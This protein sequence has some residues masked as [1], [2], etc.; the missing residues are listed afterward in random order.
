MTCRLLGPVGGC[1]SSL[2]AEGLPADL[3]VQLRQVGAGSRVLP[4]S[5]GPR[6]WAVQLGVRG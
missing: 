2:A 4:W 5:L 3:L 6:D 1:W